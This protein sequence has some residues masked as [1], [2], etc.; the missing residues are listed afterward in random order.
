MIS[1]RQ[2]AAQIGK[3]YTTVMSWLQGDLMPDAVKVTTPTGHIWS[4]P[5]GTKPPNVKMGRPKK[6][7]TESAAAQPK[8]AKKA[9]KAGN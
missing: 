2:Y 3:A 5:E 4:I 9:R 1:P 6:A 8:P 7:A